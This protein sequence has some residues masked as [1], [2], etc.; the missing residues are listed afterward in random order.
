MGKKDRL[1]YEKSMVKIDNLDNKF[2]L[3]QLYAGFGNKIFDCIIGMYLKINFGYTIYYVDTISSHTKKNDP[4]IYEVFE[5]LKKEFKF[6]TDNE[7]DYIKYF[8]DYKLF[9]PQIQKLSQLNNYFSNNNQIRLRT[10]S[11]YNLVFD[12]YN[13]FDKKTK[14]IFEINTN[15]ISPEIKSYAKTT[16]ATIHIRYG[17]KLKLAIKKNYDDK[18]FITFPIYT[19][20]YYYEQIKIIKKLNLPIVILTDSFDIIKHFLLEKYKLDSDPDIFMPNIPFIDSFYL[21]LYSSYIVMSH[22][23]FS[24]SAYLLSKDNF[25]NKP[26]VYTFCTVNEFFTIYKPAD[27]YIQKE[28]KVY[29]DKKYIL[30]FNQDLV[31]KMYEFG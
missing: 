28:W 13:S 31:K 24:Y 1:E 5:K 9:N 30:N 27:L 15:L 20:E 16:Y 18:N 10:T 4:S 8:L 21:L 7:G 22:S 12:M 29:N 23:T 6:I 19:P 26:R 17:D 14:E 11:I 25:K 3:I 2:V